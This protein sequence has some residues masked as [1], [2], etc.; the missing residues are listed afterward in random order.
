MSPES[1]FRG[2]KL[3]P[4]GSASTDPNGELHIGAKHTAYGDNTLFPGVSDVEC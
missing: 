3:T 4:E 1:S 2:K